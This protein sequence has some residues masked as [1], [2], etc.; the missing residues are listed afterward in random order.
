MEEISNCSF[1][2]VFNKLTNK[3]DCNEHFTGENCAFLACPNDCN[4][5]G[6]CENGICKC[7]KG[8]GNYDCSEKICDFSC[9]KRGVC[10]EGKCYCEHGYTGRYCAQSKVKY[11]L[12]ISF[13]RKMQKVLFISGEMSG[14][15]NLSVPREILWRV[16]PNK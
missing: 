11:L 3:C 10:I 15:R 16:L 8:F 13:P 6:V 4:L 2:G 14:K 5:N 9:S 12:S 1:N 7:N